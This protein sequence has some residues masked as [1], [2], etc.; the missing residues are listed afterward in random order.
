[1]AKCKKKLIFTIFCLWVPLMGVMGE[2]REVW[3]V[4]ENVLEEAREINAEL[5]EECKIRQLKIGERLPSFALFDQ[6]GQLFTD[7]NLQG[8]YTV[9]NFIFTRCTMRD[10][11]PASTA[12]MA[13]MVKLCEDG[14]T[15]L[16]TASITFD[17]EYD[18][19]GVLKHY[20]KSYET[21]VPNCRFLTGDKVVIGRLMRY[22]GI[23]T[24]DSKGRVDHT[25]ATV[26]IDPEGRVRVAVRGSDWRIED[27][28]ASIDK[29]L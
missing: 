7:K 1:M 23:F 29:S 22:F 8:G 9:L 16:K 27:V 17:P 25:M 15:F 10:K 24:V 11:C 12:R 13:E 20:A 6:D 4:D 3:P 26:L 14:G 18:T 21:D 28:L 5:M 19:P 2:C